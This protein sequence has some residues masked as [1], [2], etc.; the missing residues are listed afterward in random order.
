MNLLVLLVKGKQIARSLLFDEDTASVLRGRKTWIGRYMTACAGLRERF[1]FQ[2]RYQFTA[3]SFASPVENMYKRFAHNNAGMY[4]VN[5][6][7]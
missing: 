4:T 5:E 6:V 2:A 7:A 3:N 1:G